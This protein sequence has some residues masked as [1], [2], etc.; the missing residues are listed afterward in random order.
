MAYRVSSPRMKK[1][2]KQKSK[3]KKNSRGNL[4]PAQLN[5]GGEPVA[6]LFDDRRGDDDD[7]DD[8]RG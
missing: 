4:S 8:K 5:Y 3:G 1:F 2:T 6:P 7:D